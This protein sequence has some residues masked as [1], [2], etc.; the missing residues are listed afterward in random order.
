[1]DK[2]KYVKRELQDGT[3]SDSM[4]LIADGDYVDVNNEILTT[5]IDKTPHY[6]DTVANM[7][8]DTKLKSG[9][10]VITLGYYSVN[11]GGGANYKI[12]SST[13]NYYETL[14]NGLKA[15]LQYPDSI[16]N[17]LCFGAKGD[18]STN[19]TVAIQNCANQCAT[20]FL[21][22]YVPK[23]TTYK[24]NSLNLINIRDINIRGR[25]TCLNASDIILI[26][27]NVNLKT[28]NIYICSVRTGIIRLEGLNSADVTIQDATKVI[29]YGNSAVS[30][31]SWSAYNKFWLGFVRDFEINDD[32]TG[33]P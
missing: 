2:L 29:L 30:G 22:F 33:T 11:D 18:N 10:M 7:K 6:Y 21:T 19:D 23:D 3:Y 12:V 9:D 14:N 31:A 24:V 1:M 26:R 13:S 28:P 17:V 8:T 20:S 16:G 5:R 25:F 4:P 32:G 15:E 27:E